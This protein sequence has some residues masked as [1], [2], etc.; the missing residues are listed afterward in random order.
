MKRD[1][2]SSEFRPTLA[3]CEEPS[4]W[5]VARL[6]LLRE[7]RDASTASQLIEDVRTVS[8]HTDI[9]EVE[10]AFRDAWDVE[11]VL[12]VLFA[13]LAR[14]P[15]DTNRFDYFAHLSTGTHA[16][17]V[18]L[19]LLT[20]GRYLPGRFVSTVPPG[21][22]GGP[23]NRP[24]IRVAEPDLSRYLQLGAQRRNEEL[25]G[26]ALLKDHIETRNMSY[27][28]L[29]ERIF[30]VAR[31]TA[32]PL[33]LTGPTGSGKTALA[34]RLFRLKK[35]EQ[36]LAGNFVELNCATLTR[37]SAHS[38]L[39]GHVRG[40]FTGALH[41]RTG[42][43]KSAN[44][45]VLFLDEVGEL[46]LDVQAM[47]LTA[48][49]TQIFQPLGSDKTERSTFHLIVG[50]NRDLARSV[51]EGSFREDL[52]ARLRRWSFRLPGLAERRDDIPPNIDHELQKWPERV[53]FEPEARAHLQDWAMAPSTPWPGNFRDLACLLER[54]CTLAEGGKVTVADVR[55]EIAELERDWGNSDPVSEEGHLLQRHVNPT[56]L[57]MLDTLDRI[58]LAHALRVCASSEDLA[59]A[60]RILFDATL[61]RSPNP[62]P[63]D[64]VRKFLKRHGVDPAQVAPLKGRNQ[65]KLGRGFASSSSE[66]QPAKEG[67]YRNRR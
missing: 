8:P 14:Y 23:A 19:F 43:L 25:R 47:L 24:S 53:T 49:E 62:N 42:A 65:A 38:A 51:R 57:A 32:S 30:R 9:E 13:H 58:T 17:I 36:K 34:A 66:E 46:P 41:P 40:A 11:E 52:F 33:L 20:K 27:N 61:R 56:H 54:L 31:R 16:A 22:R 59:S 10:V 44:D 12:D 45:G 29:M 26:V 39:F 2:R 64:R 5:P 6:V 7:A 3:L 55:R 28:A 37:E 1:L 67:T 4:K 18:S 35:S 21:L 48:L 15:F 63:T 50:T 60:G